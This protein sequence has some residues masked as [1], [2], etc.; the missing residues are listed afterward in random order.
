MEESKNESEKDPSESLGSLDSNAFL[1][2]FSLAPALEPSPAP[3][4]PPPPPLPAKETTS[5]VNLEESEPDQPSTT[6][7]TPPTSAPGAIRT[8]LPQTK[9]PVSKDPTPHIQKPKPPPPP[10]PA[11]KAKT[12]RRNL[13]MDVPYNPEDDIIATRRRWVNPRSHRPYLTSSS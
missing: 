1:E 8:H 3:R 13:I 11:T 7:P 6:L 10:R 12:P 2:S 9:P 4:P 5:E